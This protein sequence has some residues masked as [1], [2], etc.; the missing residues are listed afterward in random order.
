VPVFFAVQLQWSPQPIEL[1]KAPRHAIF[2]S[3]TLYTTQARFDGRQ[4]F[5]LRLGFFSDAISAKQVAQ[6]LF[7]DFPSVAV[8]PVNPQEH[9]T[10][11]ETGKRSTGAVLSAQ[12]HADRGAATYPLAPIGQSATV[13]ALRGVKNVATAPTRGKRAGATLEETLETL[14]TSEFDMLGSDEDPNATGVRHLQVVVDRP[15]ARQ[16]K[17]ASSQRRKV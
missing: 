15:V 14:R 10:A 12:V 6:Y 16:H 2:S 8:V 5:C 7:S 9:A 1:G 11:L 3:Y 17:G 4:W 13:P